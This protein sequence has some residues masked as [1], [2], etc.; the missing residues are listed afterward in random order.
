MN[1]Q[2]SLRCAYAHSPLL[3]SKRGGVRVGEREN[4]CFFCSIGG[5]MNFGFFLSCLYILRF[6]KFRNLL[7]LT[8]QKTLK[9]CKRVNLVLRDA[10][11]LF[12]NEICSKNSWFILFQ[13]KFV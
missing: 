10:L 5:L 12:F 6:L 4:M 1:K 7:K 11:K 13:S 3:L 2:P 9:L 8:F